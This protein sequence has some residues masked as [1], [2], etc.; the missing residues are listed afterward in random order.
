MDS[1]GEEFLFA[2][3]EVMMVEAALVYA[4]SS[5]SWYPTIYGGQTMLF[6]LKLQRGAFQ[7]FSPGVFLPV[8]PLASRM[9]GTCAMS[10]FSYKPR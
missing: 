9:A 6:S 10:R 3:K 5:S 4:R 1:F 7:F 2:E 8:F